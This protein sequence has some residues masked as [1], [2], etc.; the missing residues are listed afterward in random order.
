M[1][2]RIEELASVGKDTA[3]VTRRAAIGQPLA[4]EKFGITR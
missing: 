1:A 4:S 3:I 2:P